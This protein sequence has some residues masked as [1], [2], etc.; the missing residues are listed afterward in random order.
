MHHGNR[1]RVQRLDDI[2]PV[3][4]A[5]HRILTRPVEFKDLRGHLPVKRIGC[6]GERAASEGTD[7][8]PAADRDHPLIVPAEHLEVG[9]EMMGQRHRLR[10]LKMCETGHISMLMLFHQ[11]KDGMQKLQQKVRDL[12]ELIPHIEA[13]IHRHLIVS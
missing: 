3:R 5:V 9:A 4:D 6:P 8:H 13:H 12:V 1:Q 2:I 11:G 10:F 7:V